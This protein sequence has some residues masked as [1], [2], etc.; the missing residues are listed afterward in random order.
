MK[1]KKRNKEL[2]T[3]THPAKGLMKKFLNSRRP[4]YSW[5]FGEFWNLRGQHNWE[6][7][8]KK[9]NMLLTTTASGQVAQTLASAISE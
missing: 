9:R 5:V 2:G 6:G 4:S 3:V 1:D 8:E 7:K